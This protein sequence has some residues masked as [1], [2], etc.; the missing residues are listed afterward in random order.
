MTEEVV[1]RDQTVLVRGKQIAAVGSS[2][3]IAVPADARIIDGTGGFLMPGLADMHIHLRGHWEGGGWPVSPFHL[4]LANGVTTIRCFGPG[5]KSGTYALRWRQEIDSGKRIGP[6]IYTCGPILYGPVDHPE[7]VVIRQKYQ[8]F[9]FIKIYSY[10]TPAEYREAMAAAQ[11]L[12]I[13]TAGHI[14]FQVGLEGVLAAKMDEI[15]HV[16]ELLWELVEFNRNEDLSGAAWMPYVTTTAFDQYRPWLGLDRAELENRLGPSIR[17]TVARLEN[18]RV[19]VCTTLFLD[20][21]IIEK[22]HHPRAFLKKPHNRYLPKWYL[23]RFRQGKEKHQLQFAGGEEFAPWKY[24]IDRLFLK[25]LKQSRVPLLLATDA[26]TGGMGLVPGFSIHD[27][28]RILVENG[29]TPYEAIATGTKNI[30]PVIRK[31]T[32]QGNLGTIAL[33]N[34]ADL[35]LVDRNPLEDVA[36][37]RNPRG[38]MAGGRWYAARTLQKMTAIG[39]A[40]D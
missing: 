28:L 18:S 20:E 4:Y 30:S 29:F 11:K 37:I 38:V 22:L 27:E 40:G 2:D 17:R 25:Q 19:P 26:G 21:V 35:L 1:L 36:N 32:G 39:A 8:G 15:A 5:G 24:H 16:E 31:M 3:R 10:V 9:D 7:R 6:Q 13:Y 14:P 33:G 12:G 23:D 34:R